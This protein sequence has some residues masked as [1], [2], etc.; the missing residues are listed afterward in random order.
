MTARIPSEPDPPSR[1]LENRTLREQVIENLREDILSNRLEPGAELNEVPL[2]RAFGISRGPLREALG[3]LAAEGLVTIV[4]RRG[5]VVTQLTRKEFIDS[6]RVRQALEALATRLAVPRLTDEDLADLRGMVDE[7]VA[8]AEAGDED[9]F[10]ELNTRFHERLVAASDNEKL[11]EFHRLLIG[12]MR[13]MRSFSLALRGNLQ[14]SID[15]HRALLEAAEA[16]DADRAARLL[17][18]HVAVPIRLL[19]STPPNE[20]E[21][22]SG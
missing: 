10:F 2:A 13:R 11:R 15:E 17:E 5:A 8:R 7:M 22:A 9:G 1:L 4:P 18:E 21:E 3:R 16:G 20:E 14:Q 12:Q 6:Y 19:E